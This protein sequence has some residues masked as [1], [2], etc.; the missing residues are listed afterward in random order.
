MFPTLKARFKGWTK[1]HTRWVGV[2][3]VVSPLHTIKP[4][5][6]FTWSNILTSK[7]KNVQTQQVSDLFAKSILLQL[8]ES[9]KNRTEIKQ[10]Q[11]K[12]EEKFGFREN[13]IWFYANRVVNQ[14]KFTDKRFPV[15]LY[16]RFSVRMCILIRVCLVNLTIIQW[17]TD[18]QQLVLSN[19]GFNKTAPFMIIFCDPSAGIQVLDMVK[20]DTGVN[21]LF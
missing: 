19:D 8:V 17:S 20:L 2:T 5:Q 13:Y 15:D 10:N 6:A 11:G 12:L 3:W 1:D 7:R 14:R 16:L 4:S 21:D 9:R 18:M